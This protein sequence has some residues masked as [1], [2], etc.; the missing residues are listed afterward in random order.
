MNR[1][2]ITRVFV[3]TVCFVY[4]FFSFFLSFFLSFWC[5][6]GNGKEGGGSSGERDLWD[7]CMNMNECI[8]FVVTLAFLHDNH[9]GDRNYSTL[10]A[11]LYCTMPPPFFYPPRHLQR[12]NYT[13]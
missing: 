3:F 8:H 9:P 1:E 2:S 10:V 5:E 6:K 7:V 12:V 11:H 13:V 4:S